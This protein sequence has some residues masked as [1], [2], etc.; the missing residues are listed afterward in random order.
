MEGHGGRQGTRRVLCTLL[1]G[2]CALAAAPASSQAQI[3]VGG[4]HV[5][6]GAGS[7]TFTITR[8]AG[9]L[10]PP[11]TVE[12]ATANGSA[13]AP[14]DYAAASGRRTFPGTIVAEGQS[15][16]VT[17]PV[18]RDRLDEPDET[19][20][21]IVSGYGEGIGTIADDDAAPTA[22][23]VD[24]PPAGEGASALF[25]IGL[26][27]ASGRDVSVAFATANGSAV[28]E[29]DYE[30][31]S[32]RVTI[33]AGSTST[34]VAVRLVDDG[35]DE[36]S[37]G[38]ELHL[39]A[40]RSVGLGDMAG[41]ATIVDNDA[42][43]A[44][45]PPGSSPEGGSGGGSGQGSPLTGS[46]HSLPQLGVSSPRLRRPSTVLVTLSCPRQTSRCSGRLTLFSRPHKRS[47]I[48]ALRSERRLGRHSFNL[49]GGRSKTL[50]IALSQRDRALLRRAGRMNVRAYV[51]TT[52][53]AGRSGVRRV[54]GT[55][56]VRTSHSG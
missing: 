3:A 15:Q 50:R 33:P 5:S 51:V 49:A 52:D 36:P 44:T 1:L 38:F 4:V 48:K 43:G 23:V 55:L 42:P 17:V 10:A 39:S 47:K 9:L 46:G 7:I 34:A 19:L 54:S 32:G 27:R 20:R 31:R 11:L 35:A 16:D 14:A 24:A 37:E 18:A 2:G 45:S 53:S 29:Q 56:V 12:F 21:L 28:A 6:E 13:T 22:G 8:Q 30:A 26:S 25:T 41:A 40:P